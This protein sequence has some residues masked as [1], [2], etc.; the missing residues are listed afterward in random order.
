MEIA[1]AV[2]IATTAPHDTPWPSM[3]SAP[4]ALVPVANRPLIFHDLD[5]LSAAGVLETAIAIEPAGS[6]AMRSAIGDGSRWRMNVRFV[7]CGPAPT[8]AQVLGGASGFIGR[9]PVLVQHAG[10]LLR[11][12]IHSHITAFAGERLDALALRLPGALELGA[13]D[14][15]ALDGS[16]LLSERAIEILAGDEL[17][18][19]PLSRVR[20]GGGQVRVQEVDG[21]LPCLGPQEL[22]LE[23]NRR[24]LETLTPS[25]P[26]DSVLDSRVQGP[27]VIHPTAHVER[28][29]VR[30]PAVIGPRARVIDAYVG[31]STSIGADVV[32]EGAEVEY[33]IILPGACLAFVG[34]R[35]QESIIGRDAKVRRAFEPPSALRMALG[36]GAEVV[37]S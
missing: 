21:C 22:L 9:E 13:H 19:D 26:H 30:G 1:K 24:M 25:I 23:A 3:R 27:V 20:E 36:D 33:S 16:L 18:A 12:R 10:S 8:L 35:I 2:V 29:L 34:T 7:E 31:P 11:D 28:S 6:A 5:Q 14:D 4:K 17:R 15:G 37:L 32:V